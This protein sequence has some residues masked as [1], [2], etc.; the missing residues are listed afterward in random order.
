MNLSSYK[1]ATEE[2]PLSGDQSL[3]VQGLGIDAIVAMVRTQGDVMRD[4][5]E[6]A[7]EGDLSADN[8][9][10]LLATLLDEGPT[11]VALIIAFGC[12]EPDEWEKCADMPFADQVVL[13]EAIV[14][15]TFVSEGG[16]KK[17]MEIIKRAMPSTNPQAD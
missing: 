3:K 14:K 12:D 6:K 2:V 13:V 5:Y 8:M 11:I 16:V 17:V 10:D 4:L 1:L 15:L 7:I 9:D